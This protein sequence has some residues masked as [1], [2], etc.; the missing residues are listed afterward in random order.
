[1]MPTFR[2]IAL[3][4]F[5]LLC[6][7]TPGTA[8]D[9]PL[10]FS[11]IYPHLAALSDSYSEAGIGAVVPWAD[12]LW[13][14]SY[15]AHKSGQ[16]VGLYE[17][18][19]DRSIRRRPESIVGTHAGRMIHRESNQLIIGPYIIDAKGN[20]RVFEQLAMTERVTA[21][22]RH[23]TEPASKVYFQAMEGKYYEADVR[24]LETTLLGDAKK[25][26]GISGPA[27]FKGAY[28]SQGRYVV[29]NN[30]YDGGDVTGRT[31]GRYPPGEGRLAEW[32]GENWTILHRTAFCDVTTAAGVRPMADDPGPLW[33]IGWDKRS[34][35]LAELRDGRWNTYRLPKG[36]QAYDQAW[37]TEW[38]RIRRASPELR[39]LDMHGLFY[40][41]KPAGGRRGDSLELNPLAYHLRMTPDFCDWRGQLV[42]AGDQNSSMNHR[43][44]TGGQPQSNLWFG[45]VDQLRHWGPPAGWGGPWLDDEIRGGDHTSDPFLIEGFTNRSLHLVRSDVAAEPIRARCTGQFEVVELPQ[46]LRKLASVTIRRGSMNEPGSGYSFD[47]NRPVVVYL[48]VHDRGDPH[49]EEGWKKTPMRVG[50]R[51]GGPYSDTVYR[52]E[53]P[54]GRINIPRHNGHN[55][56]THYGVPHMAFI[57]DA[58]PSGKPPAIIGLSEELQAKLHDAGTETNTR[59]EN[60]N[61]RSVDFRLQIDRLGSGEWSDYK[62][63]A[64]EPDGYAWHV[65]PDDLPGRWM[66]IC[67]SEE[68]TGSV[69]FYFGPSYPKRRPGTAKDPFASFSPA[70]EKKARLHGGL[71]PFADRL[72]LIAYKADASGRPVDGLGLYEIDH[73][74][75]FVRRNES[76]DGIFT[77]RKMVAG[78]LSIGPH[79]IDEEGNVRTFKVLAGKHVVASIRHPRESQQMLFLTVEGDLLEADLTSLSVKP[80]ANIPDELNLADAKLIF[81]AGHSSGNNVFVAAVADDGNSGCLARWDGTSWTVLDRAAYSEVTDWASMSQTV[82]ATGWDRASA[83]LRIRNGARPG[84][85]RWVTYRLP[86]AYAASNSAN[87]YRR[88]RIREVETERLLMDLGGI[89]YETTGLGHAWFVR[90]IA[91]HRTDISDFCSW[92]GMTVLAGNDADAQPTANYL[93][94]DNDV[95]LWFGKTDDL[96]QFAT[97]SGIGGPWHDTRVA[98]DELSEPYLMTNFE[99]KGV[100]FRHRNAA[101]VTF[102]ILVD[103]LGTRRHWKVVESIR[104]MPGVSRHHK[105]PDGY[106]AHWV[107][108]KADQD[109]EATVQFHYER[110]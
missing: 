93:H 48:A 20:V 56:L 83:I 82:V 100:T 22:A 54:I 109:C 89:F 64:V 55:E 3:A 104:V 84:L 15:V 92:R 24:T 107:R 21:I 44:R 1:M 76:I 36:S 72:W 11:G 58:S 42:L 19:P 85:G 105:F 74:M 87:P 12:R 88:S 95:G 34:V 26:L 57:A 59:R 45:S 29:A 63:L 61:D 102:T 73:D 66:R 37:C 103:P 41:M 101:P 38:P 51:H 47:V 97:P 71:L 81:R 2:R 49:L 77:N 31:T 68:T 99:H 67:P 35:L 86:N 90:P 94:G 9:P 28:T 79:L 30:S 10:S 62:T 7:N 80:L 8:A 18:G 4:V 52:Q 65:L 75:K 14:V 60:G 33:A 50:W 13:Y 39:M 110:Q 23:L 69:Q 17:I 108:V 98:A 40:E 78:Q 6:T 53:F 96:W 25:E 106:S 91:A 43:N 46:P 70:A 27:H 5:V 32:D 16:R